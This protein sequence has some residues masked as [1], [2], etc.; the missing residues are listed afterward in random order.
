MKKIAFVSLLLLAAACNSEQ[1]KKKVFDQQ[2]NVD[3]SHVFS[4][5]TR[6]DEKA[7][8]VIPDK[9]AEVVHDKLVITIVGPEYKGDISE[10]TSLDGHFIFQDGKLLK[11]MITT[12]THKGATTVD[13]SEEFETYVV[14]PGDSVEKI[15]KAR[16]ISPNCIRAKS[17]LH[18]YTKIKI[19]KNCK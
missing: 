6:A 18:R 9:R 16:G 13:S 2:T 11:S 1:D 14:Q 4:D 19:K 8:E 15:A 17:P 12:S 10:V 3:S 7:I 5:S